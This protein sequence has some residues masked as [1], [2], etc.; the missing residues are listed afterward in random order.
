MSFFVYILASKRNGTLYVGMADDLV[1][2]IWQ[3]RTGAL[4]GFTRKYN[5]KTLVWCETHESRESAFA[6]ERQIK[7]WDRSWKIDLIEKDNPD[8]RDLWEEIASPIPSAFPDGIQSSYALSFA[9]PRGR[10][11]PVFA[12]QSKPSLPP[13]DS[14]FRGNER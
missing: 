9:H 14:R 4:P 7:K 11:D 8:W 10:G 12:K 2:R 1:K 5:V 13:L 3:H 6:R